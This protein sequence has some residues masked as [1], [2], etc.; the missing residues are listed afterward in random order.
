MRYIGD[1]RTRRDNYILGLRYDDDEVSPAGEA[2]VAT[3]GVLGIEALVVTV[4]ALVIDSIQTDEYYDYDDYDVDD[5]G[6]CKDD[7]LSQGESDAGP[8]VD[9]QVYEADLYR[10]CV[11]VDLEQED[12]DNY[13]HD[14]YYDTNDDCTHRTTALTKRSVRHAEHIGKGKTEEKLF[15][16]LLNINCHHKYHHSNHNFNQQYHHNQSLHSQ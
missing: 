9:R 16:M 2:N 15:Y 6:D 1:G 4:L 13:K 8:V 12:D 7:D 10:G 5:N 3:R 11:H 14:G